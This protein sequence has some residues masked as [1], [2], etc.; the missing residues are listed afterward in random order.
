MTKMRRT[1]RRRKTRKTRDRKRTRNRSISRVTTFPTGLPVLRLLRVPQKKMPGRLRLLQLLRITVPRAPAMP[2]MWRA[3]PFPNLLRVAVLPQKLVQM[4][5]AQRMV[6]S[7]LSAILI[8]D[9]RML[10]ELLMRVQMMTGPEPPMEARLQRQV[11]KVRTGPALLMGLTML[12]GPRPQTLVKMLWRPSMQV[13]MPEAK[14]LQR[15]ASHKTRPESTRAVK[16]ALRREVQLQ[17]Q[18]HRRMQKRHRSCLQ[19]H[20]F[21]TMARRPGQQLFRQVPPCQA[22]PQPPAAASPLVHCS[23]QRGAANGQS[24]A[25]PHTIGSRRRRQSSLPTMTRFGT[26]TACSHL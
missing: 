21:A 17:V 6:S 14:T 3:T 10:P 1:R 12:T 18:Q 2:G 11:L 4:T 24:P 13:R 15:L 8:L 5:P 25:A 7:E 22:S 19:P 23:H 9:T 26:T 16:L 20:R